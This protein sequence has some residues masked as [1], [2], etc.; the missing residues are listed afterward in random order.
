MKTLILFCFTKII[1]MSDVCHEQAKG[2]Q[3][4][5]ALE[6]DLSLASNLGK[7]SRGSHTP[8]VRIT[9][10]GNIKWE[11]F[12]WKKY[13]AKDITKEDLEDPLKRFS[14]NIVKSSRLVANC[15]VPDNRDDACLQE[16]YDT[17]FPPAS[18]IITYRIRL[19]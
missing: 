1:H 9:T 8:D 6:D 14:V 15:T 12:D 5:S 13:Q 2:D 11:E 16:E 19:V 10:S 4:C 18:I 17:D 7:N 3:G